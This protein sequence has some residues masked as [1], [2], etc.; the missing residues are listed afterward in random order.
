ML[1]R[2]VCSFATYHFAH[3]LG[4]YERFLRKKSAL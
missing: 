2:R 3:Q 4:A 1:Q